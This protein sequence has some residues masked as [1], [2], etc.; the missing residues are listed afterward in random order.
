MA[1]TEPDTRQSYLVFASG[2]SWYAV[3][4]ESAAEVVTFPELTRVPGAPPHLLGVFAHRGE[5][6][7]V[8]DMSLLVSG[9]SQ[10]TR[11]AV[12]VR[13]SRGSL[14]L[15]ASVVAGVSPVSGTLEPLGASGV[16]VHLRG[17]A[18]SAQR[19]VAVIDPDGLFELLSQGG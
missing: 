2:N 11:R 6:I 8:V 7:P 16:H 10:P 14:A 9:A 5:V 13:L 18:K 12:L 17:P 3:P 1:V 19:D 15:T 4:A